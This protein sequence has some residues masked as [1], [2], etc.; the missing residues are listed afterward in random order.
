[1]NPYVEKQIDIK[2]YLISL[3]R[4][5]WL[6]VLI[7][8]LCGAALAGF[9]Y[10]KDKRE[11]DRLRL[12]LNNKSPV[13]NASKS[14]DEIKASMDVVDLQNVELAVEYYR[15]IKQYSK[16][17]ENS[18]Y[19]SQNPYKVNKTI[20]TYLVILDDSE[21]LS[22]EEQQVLKDNIVSCCVNYINTGDFAD[23]IEKNVGVAP[24]YIKELVRASKN[25]SDAYSLDTFDIILINDKE[26]GD[27]SE[28]VKNDIESYVS[29]ADGTFGAF[30]IQ[31]VEEYNTTVID[32]DLVNAVQGVQTDI[33]NATTR[34]KTL[35][36]AFT[37]EQL[38][39]YNNAIGAVDVMV[40]DSEDEEVKNE[41]I[42]V[43]EPAEF[44]VK[45]VIVGFALGLVFYCGIIL[46]WF[47]FS[48]RV[49]AV[50]GFESMFGVK[51]FGILF[52]ESIYGKNGSLLMK[53]EY[54]NLESVDYSTALGL[55]A[56]KI[57]TAC[58]GIGKL[59]V[60]SS[61][62]DNLN[63][64]NYDNLKERLSLEGIEL[65]EIKDALC[66]GKALKE[67]I[68]IGNCIAL[69]K[70][71]STRI[72]SFALIKELCNECDIKLHGVIDMG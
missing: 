17:E 51:M 34:L 11:N 38:I 49:L 29:E 14:V 21:E 53:L 25:S 68:S 70:S 66:D 39:C 35:K 57:K 43:I 4:Y 22:F 20:L 62:F 40:S 2:K 13:E 19:L 24:Q 32:E 58:K 69:E 47:M 63:M 46:A 61:D 10:I 28:F 26:I 37:K 45:Y 31:I 44:N 72:K 59:A 23:G 60:L 36:K 15:M 54:R 1:M 65:V 56:I 16:Y 64:D 52:P 7:S 55:I 41:Q 50:S 5:W 48:T 18:I 3:I 71:G 27:I 67:L 30:S 8:A 12:E 42:T 33:Y 6:A 9:M